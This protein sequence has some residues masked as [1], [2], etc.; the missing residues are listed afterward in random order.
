MITLF[1]NIEEPKLWWSHNI[2][3]PF[4]YHLEIK[5]MTADGANIAFKT[6]SF[7]V[8]TVELI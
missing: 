1:F 8:R 5:L 2:G 4:L 6:Q 7:G 3:E